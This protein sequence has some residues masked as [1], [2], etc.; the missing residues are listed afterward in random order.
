VE[1]AKNGKCWISISSAKGD[2]N[3]KPCSKN[4]KAMMN[5]EREVWK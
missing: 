5:N 3:G 4:V 1:G 2:A